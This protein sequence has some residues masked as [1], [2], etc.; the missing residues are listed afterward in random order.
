MLSSVSRCLEPLMKHSHSFLIY[1]F[2]Q[3]CQSVYLRVQGSGNEERICRVTSGQ[4]TLVSGLHEMVHQRIRFKTFDWSK[5]EPSR[6][7][8]MVKALASIPAR[9]HMWFEFAAAASLACFEGFSEFS[10]FS[11]STNSTSPNSTQATR[12][13]DLYEKQLRLMWLPPWIL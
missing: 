11:P 1:Y 7:G 2:K 6:D 10:R 13:E 8:A 9:S 4:E 3:R 12:I 5:N